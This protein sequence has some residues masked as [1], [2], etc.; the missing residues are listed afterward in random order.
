MERVRQKRERKEMRKHQEMVQH[1]LPSLH[2][3]FSN[4]FAI[5]HNSN[6]H[7]FKLRGLAQN[8]ETYEILT[9]SC[10]F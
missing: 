3:I 9:S 1:F 4:V 10:D 6:T 7:I 2:H 8:S 5:S